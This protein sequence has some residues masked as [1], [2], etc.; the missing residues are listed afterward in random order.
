MPLLNPT[1]I[2]AAIAAAN[3]IAE[4]KAILQVLINRIERIHKTAEI[5]KGETVDDGT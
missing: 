5:D 3:T 2:R 1:E 4:L